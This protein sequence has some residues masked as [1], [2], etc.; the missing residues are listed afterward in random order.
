MK[1][2]HEWYRVSE[3]VSHWCEKCGAL[4]QPTERLPSGYCIVYPLNQSSKEARHHG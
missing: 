2:R 3:S 1:C 4:K